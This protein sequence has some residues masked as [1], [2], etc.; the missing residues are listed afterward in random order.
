MTG[1]G[2]WEQQSRWLE[3]WGSKVRPP[4]G[5]VTPCISIATPPRRHEHR[6]TTQVRY[7]GE[8]PTTRKASSHAASPSRRFRYCTRP[9]W[10][11]GGGRRSCYPQFT[12]PSTP[13]TTSAAT[14]SS[15]AE[16]TW[17]YEVVSAATR[18]AEATSAIIR[19][20]THTLNNSTSL[21]V[22]CEGA[23][24]EVT[25]ATGGQYTRLRGELG[26][27]DSAPAG[28]VVHVLVLA[29]GDPVQNV[30]LDSDDA[31]AVDINMLLTDVDAV[32]IRSEAIAGEC[33]ASDESYAVLGNGYVE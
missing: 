3:R 19:G 18:P 9:R 30:Q 29:D 16:R 8:R 32:T 13:A 31:D 15:A 12:A 27:R 24:D 2:E 4:T 11:L 25:L 23:A 33:A 22:G 21:W 28:L 14:T 1:A 6:L 20:T 17:A 26:L 7:R 5:T 10:M